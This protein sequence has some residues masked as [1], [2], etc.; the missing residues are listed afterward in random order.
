M[1]M[2]MHIVQNAK[3]RDLEEWKNLLAA[4]DPRYQ[5]H[6][7]RQIKGSILALLDIVWES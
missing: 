7:V 2:H 3:E 4:A 5:L 6:E 1:D